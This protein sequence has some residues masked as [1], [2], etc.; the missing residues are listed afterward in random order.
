[1]S[2]LR[3]ELFLLAIPLGWLLWKFSLSFGSTFWLRAL[4]SALLLTALAGPYA[5]GET[6]G[7]DLVVLVDRSRSMPTGT[8]GAVIEFLDLSQGAME[9]GDRVSIVTFGAETAIERAPRLGADFGGFQRDLD[10]DGSHLAD[11]LDQALALLP[12]NRPGSIILFSDGEFHGNHPENSAR[13]AGLRNVRI[14]VRPFGREK[15]DDVAVESLELPHAVAPGEPFQFSAWVRSDRAK[16]V[17][18]TLFRG[19]TILA[20]GT[21]HLRAGLNHLVFRDRGQNPGLSQYQL[22]LKA[23]GDV[24]GENNTAI[25]VLK[26]EGKRPILLV[27][28]SGD[29]GRLVSALQAA[30]IPTVV[31][32]AKDLPRDAA[33]LESFSTVVL[34]DIDAA[35]LGAM[36]PAL[37]RQVEDL[38]GG[39]LLTGG[40]ASFG[41]GGYYRSDLETVL[42]VT[43]EMRVEH[44]KQGVAMVVVLDRSGSMAA[45]ATG[46]LTKMD[47]ANAGT[48]EGIRLLGPMDQVAVIA[49]DSTPH[50]IVPLSEVDDP[51]IFSSRVSGIRSQGGG[52]YTYTGLKAAAKE[53]EGA[54]RLNRHIILFADAA[55]AEEP[56]AYK[57]LLEELGKK[58]TTVSVVALG[59]PGDSDA[60]FLRDVAKRG[61]GQIYFT[62]SPG[63]LPRLFAQD[64]LLAARSAFIEESTGS[65]TVPGLYA[66]GALAPGPWTRLPGYNLTYLRPEASVGAVTTDEYQAPLLATMQAGLGRSAIFAGQV[67]GPFGVPEEDWKDVAKALVTLVRWTSAQDPPSHYFPEITREGREAH[68]VIEVDPESAKNPGSIEVR[69][70]APDGKSIRIPLTPVGDSKFEGRMPVGMKGVYRFAATTEAGENFSL[71]PL[72]IPYSPEFEPRPEELEGR[73]TLGRLARL[74]GGQIDPSVDRA[75]QGRRGGRGTEP[76]AKWFV[77]AGLLCLLLEIALRRLGLPAFMSKTRQPKVQ[78]KGVTPVPSGP[79]S[80]PSYPT[81]KKLKEEPTEST[82]TAGA[83]PRGSTA[84]ADI[85]EILRTAKEKARKRHR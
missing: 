16:K 47:L 32:S 57:K 37:K 72:A 1:M 69:A 13:R 27:N 48:M 79:S 30:G 26:V 15:G 23:E 45:P 53:L 78:A 42:P 24:I 54:T 43:M 5:K 76:Q 68:I 80:T 64:T 65:K 59:S 70:V 71:E 14:D 83:I 31:R 63:E 81:A 55:D 22:R 11:A 9:V 73:A 44:R 34:E 28:H 56:G 35:S 49:V 51:G 2:F 3:P 75:W 82:G 46:K 62:T 21:R 25:G 61:N 50:V 85:D 41:V 38:A 39:L 84:P 20:Q 58:N 29:S 77:I 7:R 12:E 52:I 60:D 66:A 4:L 67:D 36:L 19:E 8:L 33:F 18:F 17:D 6:Q 10:A 74:S 40:K